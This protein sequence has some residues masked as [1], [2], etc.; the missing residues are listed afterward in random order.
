MKQ[1][2]NK[3][4]S[5]LKI[6][7]YRIYYLGQIV[8]VSG[9]FLQYLAQVWLVLK[10]SNSALMLGFIPAFQFLPMLL[11]TSWGGLLADRYSKLKLLYI[12]Q[13]LSGILALILGLLVLTGNVQLWMVF[14]FAL[15]LGLINSIDNPA[16]STFIFEMVGSEKIKNAVSLWTILISS[17]RIIGPAIAGI[18]VATIGIGECFVI[19]AASYIAVLIG[20]S[21]I[22]KSELHS[23]PPV[24]AA[25]KG[26]IKEGLKYVRST[27]V[28]FNTLVMMAIIGTITFEWQVSMPLFAKFILNGDAGVYSII[29]VSLGIGMLIGGVANASS[30]VTSQKRMGYTALL[31]GTTVLISAFT[32]TLLW[33]TIAFIFVGIFSMAFVNLTSSILQINTDSKMR[34]RVMAL[35]SMAFLGSTAIGGPLIGWVGE[36]F[37]VRW[38]LIVGGIAA[39]IAGVWGYRNAGYSG[40][41]IIIKEPV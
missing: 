18:I 17:A 2:L 11:L 16:R 23:A 21:M 6:R 12:T 4:F 1:Y 26:Q 28:L 38:T 29:N 19:N 20:L 10:L 13:T 15:C 14:V 36:V 5:S 32:S 41:T 40:D 34:G 27:P 25:A 30:S 24:D 39:L 33:A 37:G 9:T 35:W 7:N 8:S 22:R 31:F 3:T